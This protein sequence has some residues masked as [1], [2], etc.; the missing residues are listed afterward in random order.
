MKK[1]SLLLFT[2]LFLIRIALAQIPAG[3]YDA[4]SGLTGD[5]LRSALKTIIKTGHVKLSYAAV[6]SAFSTTDVR[7]VPNNTKIWDMYSDVPGG[8][9]AYTYTLIT[10]QCGSAN[11]EGD[12]Y[13]REHVL[14]NSWWGGLDDETHP[15]YS[16]LHEM[17]PAD[18][19]V[20]NYKS[21]HP[22]GQVGTTT[23]TSTNGTK[24][25]YSSISGY[26]GIVFEPINEYK[27]DFARAYLY[28]A[29]RYKD[30]IA[31]W[32]RHYST[33]EAKYIIDTN[34]NNYKQWFIDM[35][36]AWNSSD[37]VSTKE[38]NRNN[39]V[40]ALQHNRNPFIDHPEYVTAIWA[41]TTG[42]LPEPTNYASDFSAHSLKLQ[43]TD[44]TGS[45][46]PDGY[47]IIM[48]SVGYNHIQPPVDGVTINDSYFH[49]NVPYG[50]QEVTFTN[51][52]ANKL[53]YFKIYPYVG[54][55]SDINYKT[56]G[57]IPQTQQTT[58]P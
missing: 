41:P 48:D 53:Y 56:S 15:Q 46:L 11:S 9:P 35:L 16:D 12:C 33:T 34:T 42:I 28:A 36:L 14:P 27:G 37:P 55:G 29:T 17:F 49:K 50:I 7:A 19:Y 38:I 6:W 13:S 32:V 44:A 4:A 25:G 39:A 54:Y 8:T 24:V 3:Y 31:N 58:F 20:N 51:L 47:L 1:L 30:D 40:Y 52:T 45:N 23:F 2:F 57:L 26:V 10:N 18:Q 43:W 22:L 5:N 21:A